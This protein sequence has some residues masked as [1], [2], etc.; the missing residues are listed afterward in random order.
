[1]NKKIKIIELSLLLSF[2]PSRFLSL[3]LSLNYI[4][5]QKP[6][7]ILIT[8]FID[9]IL[10]LFISFKKNLKK[11]KIYMKIISFLTKSIT[12]NVLCSIIFVSILKYV[13]SIERLINLYLILSNFKEFTIVS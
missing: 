6:K 9:T 3:S 5:S 12:I 13:F 10:T 1:M 11:K 7:K 4:L 2:P 8:L